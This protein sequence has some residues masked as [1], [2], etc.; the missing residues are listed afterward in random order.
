MARS[1]LIVLLLLVLAAP[2]AANTDCSPA[3]VAAARKQFR[4][5]YDTR[6][7]TKARN[8]LRPFVLDC[9]GEDPQGILAASMLSDLAIA[10]HHAGDDDVCIEALEPYAPGTSGSERR[11]SGLPDELKKA[12]LFNL[13]RCTRGC[14]IVDAPCQSIRASLALEKLVKGGI[15]ASACSFPAGKD[16]VA[17]PGAAGHCLTILPPRRAGEAAYRDNADP[18]AVCPRPELARREGKAITRTEIDLPNGSWLRDLEIC[19]VRPILTVTRNGEV[20]LV[21]EENP[22]EGCLTGHRT[23]VVQEIYALDRGKLRLI[24]KVREG[25]Y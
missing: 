20:V 8:T 18:R 4:N 12:I 23:Y 22:P 15:A 10:A 6:D 11:L 1:C 21:P 3:G 24:H 9:F 5:Y 19:C 2:A 14:N 13:G 7:Y 16:A 17:V 25:V